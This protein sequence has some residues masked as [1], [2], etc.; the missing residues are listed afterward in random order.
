M[1]PQAGARRQDDHVADSAP[2]V[3]VPGEHPHQQQDGRREVDADVVPVRPVRQPLV[4]QRDALQRGLVGQA[5][6][7]LQPP[8][9]NSVPECVGLAAG[10]QVPAQAVADVEQPEQDDL[11]HRVGEQAEP[12]SRPPRAHPLEGVRGPRPDAGEPGHGPRPGGR[13]VTQAVRR[14]GGRRGGA[15]RGRGGWWWREGNQPRQRHRYGR[16]SLPWQ[17]GRRS[18][19]HVSLL[20]DAF[21]TRHKDGPTAPDVTPGS[22][23]RGPTLGK[24]T[25]HGNRFRSATVTAGRPMTLGTTDTTP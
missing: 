9:V 2:V 24:P 16:G 25:P 22:R 19:D 6:E 8:D 17:R 21:R 12:H 14:A 1:D 5:Q 15:A 11:A 4:R 18:P 23:P 3:A 10:S 20:V 13:R 7:P